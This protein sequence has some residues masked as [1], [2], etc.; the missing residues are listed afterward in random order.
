MVLMN[1]DLHSLIGISQD[2]LFYCSMAEMQKQE[3][4]R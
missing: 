3:N 4:R 2:K 1:E